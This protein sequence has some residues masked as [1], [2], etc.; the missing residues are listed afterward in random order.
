[1]LIKTVPINPLAITFSNVVLT[2]FTYIFFKIHFY[3]S[4]SI[5]MLNLRIL[6]I[7]SMFLINFLL[8][9][10]DFFNFPKNPRWPP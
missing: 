1:M 3:S 10:N 2:I 4:F 9:L 5:Q 8:I 7:F 6:D